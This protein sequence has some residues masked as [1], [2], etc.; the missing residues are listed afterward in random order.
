MGSVAVSP[1]SGHPPWKGSRWPLRRHLE[2]T[3]RRRLSSGASRPCCPGLEKPMHGLPSRGQCW[4]PGGLQPQRMSPR[5]RRCKEMCL[6]LPGW[7]WSWG[8]LLRCRQCLGLARQPLRMS[9]LGLYHVGWGGHVWPREKGMKEG[10]GAIGTYAGEMSKWKM[11]EESPWVPGPVPVSTSMRVCNGVYMRWDG[12]GTGEYVLGVSVCVC[13]SVCVS[14]W[15]QAHPC[16]S[17]VAL[18]MVADTREPY[19]LTLGLSLLRP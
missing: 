17:Q 16:R 5:A 7:L 6:P 12:C 8:R 19:P 11:V 1:S 3:V 10:V 18:M 2:P 14:V 13:L 4:V 15:Q 9:H